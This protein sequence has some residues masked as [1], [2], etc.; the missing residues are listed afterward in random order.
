MARLGCIPPETMPF[1]EFVWHLEAI[2]KDIE[3]EEEEARKQ[4]ARRR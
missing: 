3:R 4:A 2:K 1:R